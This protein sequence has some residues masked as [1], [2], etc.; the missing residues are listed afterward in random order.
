MN[1]EIIEINSD[2][3]S[4]TY[5]IVTADGK[6][7]LCTESETDT[8]P[9]LHKTCEELDFGELWRRDPIVAGRAAHALRRLKRGASK[10]DGRP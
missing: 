5:V 4:N 3:Q 9:Y 1:H 6:L 2:N 10:L 7:T 8:A